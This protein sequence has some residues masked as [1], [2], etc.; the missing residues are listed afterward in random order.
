MPHPPPGLQS[1]SQALGFG[2][3]AF[4]RVVLAFPN[5]ERD[6]DDGARLFPQADA[7]LEKPSIRVAREQSLGCGH[8]RQH[9]SW[10]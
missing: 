4:L 6:A 7:N 2:V 8:L 9:A 5:V 1:S 10:L 3:Q